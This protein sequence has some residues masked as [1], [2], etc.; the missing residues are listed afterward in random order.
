MR[1]RLEL[2]VECGHKCTI[3]NCY[4]TRDL[5][6]HHINSN[7][8]DNRKE[9]LVMFCPNHHTMADRGEMSRKECRKYKEILRRSIPISG[10]QILETNRKM[11]KEYLDTLLEK[12]IRRHIQLPQTSKNNSEVET[13]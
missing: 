1:L 2:L 12:I 10:E 8:S 4:Q 3:H 11:L 5:E 13:I 7:P 9:N 6:V